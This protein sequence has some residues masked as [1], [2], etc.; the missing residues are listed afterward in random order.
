MSKA[1]TTEDASRELELDLDASDDDTAN[2]A[3]SAAPNYITPAG[4][5]KLREELHTLLTVT[6]PEMTATVAWAAGNG[7]RSENGDYIY[8]KRRLREIDKKIRFLTKRIDHAVVTDPTTQTDRERVY[9]GATVTVRDEDAHE[10]RYTIVGVDEI[11]LKQRRISWQSP[12]AKAL[13][14]ARLRDTVIFQSP[15]GER[16]L[17]ILQIVYDAVE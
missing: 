5:K 12:L 4:V 14:K 3:A 15:K 9:F 11:D 8:G 16:E 1:F 17:E 2:A 7:D 10:M 6:R 13:L